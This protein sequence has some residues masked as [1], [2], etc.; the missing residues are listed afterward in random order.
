MAISGSGCVRNTLMQKWAIRFNSEP[1]KK[2][3]LLWRAARINLKLRKVCYGMHTLSITSHLF[4]SAWSSL[5]FP[6]CWFSLVSGCCESVPVWIQLKLIT[7]GWLEM[8]LL[9]SHTYK[10]S[11]VLS[12]TKYWG[13]V[14]PVG[15]SVITV[16]F[17]LQEPHGARID[18]TRGTQDP[19][20][21]RR[22]WKWVCGGLTHTLVLFCH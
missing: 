5:M 13:E 20:H 8:K 4:H 16:S 22:V 7:F 12:A 6:I 17:I 10:L 19:L 15:Q 2:L 9:H 21:Q 18:V 3:G 1:H 14:L 11:I